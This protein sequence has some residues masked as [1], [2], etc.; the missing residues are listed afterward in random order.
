MSQPT[1]TSP[2]PMTDVPEPFVKLSDTNLS[3]VA[4]V[5]AF[6][7]NAELAAGLTH[8][9]AVVREL[10][11]PLG[12]LDFERRTHP[13]STPECAMADRSQDHSA[14]HASGR[15]DTFARGGHE[16]LRRGIDV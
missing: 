16:D 15:R 5:N 8:S 12:H 13:R 2:G 3:G 1:Q 9:E 6:E 14:S 7:P 10:L 11:G 4:A